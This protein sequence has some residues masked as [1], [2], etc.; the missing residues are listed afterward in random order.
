[1]V[2]LLEQALKIHGGLRL[3]ANKSQSL[4]TPL[5]QARIPERLFVPLS[6]HIGDAADPLVEVGDS[7]LKGQP[8]ARSLSYISAPVH[9]PTSGRVTD[10]GTYPVP[11]PSGLKADCIVIEADGEDRAVPSGLQMAAVF[12]ADPADIRQR[13]RDAGIVGLGGAGFPTSVKLNPG[14]GRE[15]E[16]LVINAAEC[17]PYISCDEALMCYRTQEVI[18]GVRV[19]RHALHAR[20]TVIGIEDNMPKAIACLQN[21]LDQAGDTDIRV[22]AVPTVYPAGGEKQLIYTL[23]GEEV[24]SQ[25]LPIDLGI[26]CH[27]VGTAAAVG[28]A[29]LQGEPLISRVVTVTGSGI[30]QAANLDVRI[31]TPI[32]ELIEQC[33]GYTDQVTRLLMGGPMMGVSLPSDALPVIKTTNCIL[34]A[35]RQEAPQPLPAHP[36]IRCGKCAEVCPASLLPQQL[37]WYAHARNFDKA[38]DY[39]L[40]DC[41]EC[42]CC[43]QVCPSHIP[44]VQYYRFAKT[45]IWNQE[46]EREK[47]DIAR[48]RH[49]FHLERLQREKKELQLRRAKAKKAL[50]KPKAGDADSKKAEITA[51]LERVKARKAKQSVSARNTDNLSEEQRAEIR[52]IDKRRASD[53]NEKR[54]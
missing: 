25:G 45:E 7:I 31:G 39:K 24:P 54:P 40:F 27:N 23:T 16:L 12:E 15:V 13:V 33:G 26:V 41:I 47:A 36:C 51:A 32:A 29:L 37:F 52:E 34:A 53:G 5:R 10:I 50:N 46:R 42:G 38:Q 35:G 49:E 11:H 18:G 22:I 1:V 48:Q 17:E 2:T 20:Q 3:D 4:R 30:R 19:M 21:E 6:Q 9:A 8:I 43:A 44:L 14:P 28:R